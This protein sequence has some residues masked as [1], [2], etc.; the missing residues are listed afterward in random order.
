[1]SKT[2][3]GECQECGTHFEGKKQK[4]K[5]CSHACRM[6]FTNR[7][8]DR[9]AELYDMFMSM[10]FERGKAKDEGVWT[11]LCDRASA[12]KD[13][14]KTLRNGRKSWRDLDEVLASFPLGRAQGAGDLR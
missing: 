7:R 11:L 1:M 5:F 12:Y 14:D 13:S 4:A 2:F 8:R 3:K 9:G 6:A 10:R